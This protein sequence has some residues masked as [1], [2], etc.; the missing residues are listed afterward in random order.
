[1]TP[2][3]PIDQLTPEELMAEFS[4]LSS[5]Q[6]QPQAP[7]QNNFV[8]SSVTGSGPTMT[9]LSA[10]EME[11]RV[12]NRLKAELQLTEEG[13]KGV[14]SDLVG[15]TTMAKE[16][17]VEIDKAMKDLFPNGR[18]SLDRPVAFGS[19]M[20]FVQVPFTNMTTPQVM[21]DLPVSKVEDGLAEKSQNTFRRVGTSLA[22]RQLIQTGVSSR[23]EETARLVAQF[24]PNV[25]SNPNAAYD[26][27]V[28]ARDF[29]TKFLEIVDPQGVK[30]VN[31]GQQPK[32]K[33][34]HLWGE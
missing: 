10:L 33:F 16:A 13:I 9:N 5:G 22:G 8:V 17:L 21:P 3:K 26:G 34:S 27:L 30:G 6:A 15:R 25:F 7:G 18:G 23:P 32:S 31:A 24:A 28:Q 19:N 2:Q 14:G 12:K 4:S 11:E 20:P 1:M 29:Y